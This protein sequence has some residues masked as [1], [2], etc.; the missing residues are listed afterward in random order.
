[1]NIQNEI[2]KFKFI[3]YIDHNIHNNILILMKFSCHL[4]NGWM[5]K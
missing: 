4:I 1:M 5:D 3:C 2:I